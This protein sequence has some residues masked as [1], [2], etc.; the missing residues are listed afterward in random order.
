MRHIFGFSRNARMRFQNAR[1]GVPDAPFSRNCARSGSTAGVAEE[2]NKLKQLR[3]LRLPAER[4]KLCCLVG[5]CLEKL[6][7]LIVMI[8]TKYLNKIIK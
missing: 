7:Q 5:A 6:F 1:E 3:P 2:G 4:N 8:H